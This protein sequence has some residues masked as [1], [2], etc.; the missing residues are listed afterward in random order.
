MALNLDQIRQKYPIYQGVSD[1]GI[2]DHLQ[3]TVYPDLTPQAVGEKF[4]YAPPQIEQPEEQGDTSRGFETAFKQIP[5]LGY[6]LLAAAGATGEHVFGEGGISTGIKKAGLKGY[7][8]TSEELSKEAKQS[9]SLTYAYDQ[10]KEGNFGALVDW[11]QYGIG[12]AGGQGIQ[13]L[14]TAGV[15]SAAAKLAGRTVAKEFAEKMVTAEAAKIAESEAAK[16][17]STEAITELATKKIAERLGNAGA[18]TAMGANSM[19]M[20]GGEIGGDLVANAEKSGKTLG[21]EELAKAFGW[22]LAAGALDLAGDKFGLDVML[23]KSRLFKAGEEM[24]GISGKVA[25]GAMGAAAAV[26][27]EGGTEYAQTL[28]EEA[29]K[30]NDPFSESAHQQAVDAAGLGALGGVVYGVGGGIMSEQKDNQQEGMRKLSEASNVDDAIAGAQQALLPSPPSYLE[31]NRGHIPPDQNIVFSDGSQISA[32]QFMLDRL[33]EHGNETRARAQTYAALVGQ[34]KQP[35]GIPELIFDANGKSYNKADIIKGFMENGASEQDAHD[36]IK[37]ITALP[38]NERTEVNLDPYRFLR[39]RDAETLRNGEL[40]KERESIQNENNF[41]QDQFDDSIP[42]GAAGSQDDTPYLESEPGSWEEYDLANQQPKQQPKTKRDTDARQRL[43]NAR[44]DNQA[45]QAK[46]PESQAQ[47]VAPVPATESAVSP[48]TETS[49]PAGQGNQ[50]SSFVATHELSDGTPVKHVEGD[51]YVDAE[52][53]EVVGDRYV[54]P[55]ATSKPAPKVIAQDVPGNGKSLEPAKSNWQPIGQNSQGEVIE[56]GPKGKRRVRFKDTSKVGIET[57]KNNRSN[58]DRF[59]VAENNQESTQNSSYAV[60][61]NSSEQVQN[62]Q[63]AANENSAVPLDQRAD[64]GGNETPMGAGTERSGLPDSEEEKIAADHQG[65]S[66]D[67]LKQLRDDLRQKIASQGIVTNDRDESQL[68]QIEKAIA[69]GKK[70]QGQTL[71]QG[72]KQAGLEVANRIHSWRENASGQ[73]QVKLAI[74]DYLF[75]NAPEKYNEN[76]LNAIAGNVYKLVENQKENT[77]PTDDAGFGNI[78]ESELNKKPASA[79]EGEAGRVD[80]IVTPKPESAETQKAKADLDAAL[81]DLGQFFLENNLFSKKVMPGEFDDAKLMPIMARVMDAAIRLGYAKFKDAAKFTLDT[82]REKFG[83]KAADAISIDHLQG[84]YIAVAAK[85]GSLGTDNKRDVVNVDS[86]HE[87]NNHK[88]ESKQDSQAQ[89]NPRIALAN[90]LADIFDKRSEITSKELQAEA[91]KAFGGTMAEGKYSAKDAYDAME[92]AVNLWLMK[93]GFTADGSVETAA[94]TAKSLNQLIQK[95]PTQTKRDQEMDEFQQFS[96]PPALSYV[97]NWVANIS[98]GDVMMEPSAGTGDLAVWAHNQGAKIILNELSPRRLELLKGIFPDARLFNENAEQLNNILPKDAIPTVVVMNP[99]F[100]S[101]AGR[102]Q[103]ERNT[104]NGGKHI[105]Q[106]LRRLQEGG[107]LVAI[108]GKGMAADRPAF[109]AWWRDIESKYNVRANIGISGKEY[110]KYGTTFNNQ[111]LVIDKT[112]P[113]TQPVLTGNVESVSEL[114]KLLEGIRN[115]RQRIEPVADQQT[116]GKTAGENQIQ[117]GQESQ[118]SDGGTNEAGTGQSESG[119]LGYNGTSGN[120]DQAGKRPKKANGSSDK[121]GKRRGNSNEPVGQSEGSSVGA[122]AESD[123]QA[124]SGIVYEDDG[125]PVEAEELSDSSIFAPYTPQKLKIAGAKSHPGKLVQSAAMSAV[126]PPAPT[127]KPNLPKEVVDEGLLSLAQLE[128]VV[129]AGQAHSQELPDGSR[130][131]FFIGDGTGV[132]KGREISGIIMDNIRQGRK[133]AVWISFS[134]GLVNDAKRD[135]GGIGED[136]DKIF[137]QAKIGAKNDVTAKDGILFT[138]YSMLRSGEKKQATDTNQEKGKSRLKQITDWLGP[139]F[140]GVIVFD[141]S[142]KMGNVIPVK[143]KRG[144]K[145]PSQQAIAGVNLQLALPK[146]RIVYV[147]A[148]GATEIQNLGYASRLG[149][150]GQ[151]TPFANV[152]DFINKISQGGVAAMEIISRDM[153]ALG[154]YLSR[155]LSFE[156]VTYRR[157]EHELSGLQTDIYDELAGAWQAVL[158]NVEA[159]LESNG[160]ASEPNAKSAAMSAFWGAHQRFFNQIITALQMPTVLQDMREQIGKG[161]AVVV[162]L[163]NTNEATQER[164]AR[165]A[166]AEGVDLEDLDFTPK[167]LLMEYVRNSFPVQQYEEYIDDNGNKQIRAVKDSNGNPVFNQDAIDMRERLLDNLEH[168]RVPENPIDS[169]INEFGSENVGEVTGRKRRFVYGKDEDGNLKMVE[170]K[171]G[172]NAAQ[173]DAAAFQDDKKKILIF[174]EA[175]GTGFSF[176]ADNTA[177]NKRLRVHYIL[178]PGWRADSAVQGF[179]RT[180][181]TNQAQAPEYILPTTNLKAQ[182]RFISSIARRLDQLGALTK[183]QRQATSQGMFS[184]SDNLESEYAELALEKLFRDMYREQIPGMNIHEIASA[185]GINNIL[186]ENGALI[187]DKIPDIPKFLNRLLSLKKAQ[188]DQVFGEFERIMTN[189]VDR[190]I[191]DGTYDSGMETIKALKIE[192]ADEQVAHTD[193]KSGAQ[194][195]YVELNVTNPVYYHGFDGIEKNTQNKLVGYYVG[196]AGAMKGIPYALFDAKERI[197]SDGSTVHEA[198]IVSPKHWSYNDKFDAYKNGEDNVYNRSTRAYEKTKINREVTAKEAKQLWNDYIKNAPKTE[199]KKERLLVGVVLP[200]WD[201]IIGDPKIWRIRTDAGEQLIGRHLKPEAA[202]TTLKNL[203][204]ETEVTRIPWEGKLKLIQDGNTALLANGYK[205]KQAKVANENRLEI[206]GKHGYLQSVE[207]EHLKNLGAFIERIQ[208]QERAF[209]PSGNE[210]IQSLKNVTADNPIVDFLDKNGDIVDDYDQYI[211]PSD[212]KY[213]KSEKPSSDFARFILNELNKETDFGRFP[214]SDSKD[215]QSVFAEI[216]PIARYRGWNSTKLRHEFVL[217]GHEK[218]DASFAEKASARMPFYVYESDGDVWLDVSQLK[219]GSGG[220][221]I[222]FAAGNYAYN[223]KQ[224]FIGDPE[225]LSPDAVVRR[226]A[227]MLALAIRFGTTRFMEP[228]IEQLN[229]DP[230]EGIAPLE[231]EGSDEQRVM[232]LIETFLENLHSQ[233]PEIKN[234]RYNFEAGRFEH[235]DGRPV[236]RETFERIRKDDLSRRAAKARA[237]A[238]TTRQ[239]IF[240]QSLVSLPP[241]ERSELLQKLQRWDSSLSDRGLGKLFSKEQ[242]TTGSTVDQVRPWL[243]PKLRQMEA[244]G[245]L[246]IDQSHSNSQVEAYY[247]PHNDV[248]VLVANKINADN[249]NSILSHELLHRA[250]MQDSA[251]AGAIARFDKQLELSF[252]Y[253]ARG[254]GSAIEKAA[255]KRV[256]D[257]QVSESDQLEEYRA[258]LVSEW[259]NKPDS[260]SG[261]LKKAFADF[262]AAIR[263]FLIRSGLD[264]GYIKSLTPADLA[265]LSKYGAKTNNKSVGNFSF[266]DNSKIGEESPIRY[267]KTINDYTE[268]AASAIA[269]RLSTAKTFNWWHKTVGTQFHKALIDKKYFGPVFNKS[270]QYEQDVAKFA[271]KAADLAPSILP[272][273]DSFMSAMGELKHGFKRTKDADKVADAIFDT[274]LRDSPLTDDEL[275]AYSP[276]QRKMY[277]EFF[278]AVNKSMD[279]L[280]KSEMYRMARALKIPKAPEGLSLMDTA[281]DYA[282]Q[283][284]NSNDAKSFVDKAEAIIKLKKQGYAPLMRFGQYTVD[285]VGEDGR[286]EFFGMFETEQDAKEME[287]TM[288]EEYPDAEVTRGIMSQNDWQMFKGVTPET[289]EVFAKIMNVDHDQ[290]F[291]EYLKTAVVNR[292]ALKRLIHRKKMPGFTKDIPRVLSSFITSNARSASKNMHMG[293]MVDAITRIPKQK[294]D[295]IDEAVDLYNYVQNPSA[296]GAKMRGLLFTWYLGGSAASAM[297]NM[298]QTFTTTLPYL[299]QFGSTKDVANILAKAM[300]QSA[301]PKALTGDIA[302]ALKLAD[303]EG[304]TAP[305]ELHML[306]EA[307]N[308]SGMTRTK[309]MRPLEKAWGSWFALAESYNRRVAFI[310]AYELASKNG[311]PDPFEFASNAVDQTQFVYNKS[312]R[313]NWARSTLGQTVFTFKTFSINYLEFLTRLPKQ[314]QM[315]A[316]GVL[317]LFAG[318]SGIPGADDLDD[319]ID[320]VGQGMGYNTNSKEWKEKFLTQWL[321][322][323]LASY[324]LYGASYGSPI[325]VSQRLGVGNIIPGSAILKRTETDKSRDVMEFAGPAGSLIQK[326]IQAFNAAESRDNLSSK[327]IA[328]GHAIIPKAFSDAR[329]ALDMLE[330]GHYRDSKG[331][332]VAATD[333]GDAVFKLLGLQPSS[334]AIPRRQDRYLNQ[335]IT[336]V[337]TIKADINELWAQG[338]FEKDNDKVEEAKAMLKD[339]NEKNPETPILINL[340]SIGTRVKQMRLTSAERMVKTSPKEMRGYA[341]EMLSD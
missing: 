227:N 209:I 97:A 186:D 257:A 335:D 49:S 113:T 133:K 57:A 201:R 24:A 244:A 154:M 107:R 110:A 229:G 330:T 334:V 108:V 293:E 38:V 139:D 105:E 155:S 316:L 140:D 253:A 340:K 282:E 104:M 78:S 59:L 208:W 243:S 333:T 261:A 118:S 290:A 174:S 60:E 218:A 23:G 305:H 73:A 246:R 268:Q 28:M 223:T 142:H 326:G 123:Q 22:S 188:Q 323:E 100:S 27:V 71:F 96:T 7:Q 157:L 207:A 172:K 61:R 90:A 89:D 182:K 294:G 222:Y 161:N 158:Q 332:N 237:G 196:E 298:T 232:S 254:V 114:P 54:T 183:G 329:Q 289:M 239:G 317:I 295:V 306:Q 92:A 288:Q 210:S 126:E 10:A 319:M 62:E 44:Q 170:E 324:A 301:N 35:I 264:M 131:G 242:S 285:V 86:I 141:E 284:G 336:M 296:K 40:L 338:I 230:E 5:Q 318:L 121:N 11:L 263:A 99:P 146:A 169:I 82:V 202:K 135:F 53:N 341:R 203:G 79:N 119:N 75:R 231:W 166:E 205:I 300:K 70:E 204:L 219:T 164:E 191:Q 87:I 156:G 85:H 56:E 122:V 292:S 216:L 3:K 88:Y 18:I 116:G 194:T 46:A 137:S 26:P 302:K 291:Q 4:G 266:A 272:K 314:E 32:N 95:L 31:F 274:T 83:D 177:Q 55:I 313:P 101:T 215:I 65:L 308:P 235:S 33:A 77:Q 91:D 195:K 339:W 179:G 153:K 181:R 168:I 15:G 273:T 271:N 176:H 185:M 39:E 234:A 165:K 93:Q 12:Y 226:T 124:G 269:D 238:T 262:V 145:K 267:S 258:Y 184:A 211:G 171:R 213:S 98:K 151:G 47:S 160:S 134:E 192:K 58:N 30:G 80:D 276:E 127:Y 197:K 148:T 233:F 175:G 14:A 199:T 249:I 102:S 144:V 9:D 256:I 187:D 251:I 64:N 178:Q 109:K 248:V 41:S 76:D 94:R 72:A 120:V 147:S 225:G 247:D 297:V 132:G 312:A 106:A 325:D 103:G 67:E 220:S 224:T 328:G 173:G 265:A 321:G 278:A 200:I 152:N 74:L 236:D 303:D 128:S 221:A 48:V 307:A 69:E 8:D 189:I 193:E 130:R 212:I 29:G 287:K 63:A 252:K 25:R 36:Y 270:M 337:K 250:E 163:V 275:K 228:S 304:V 2:I 81:G 136:P 310:A 50:A 331:R 320:T 198:L 34:P 37:R 1:Q 281:L 6:G 17:L 125:E 260:L 66:I 277:H 16:S 45:T 21:G 42:Y 206:V 299:H 68:R 150:W 241:G 129:Y 280:A 286:R 84:G 190:A 111:I 162:Q 19:A 52:G 117:A 217:A 283:A 112:G 322:K 20:E 149:L 259:Q 180:H 327:L 115:E 245:R 315:I 143:G 309:W 159:A 311:N 13:M 138:S 214:V 43:L 51:V 240:I 167:Q 255:Y 279:D